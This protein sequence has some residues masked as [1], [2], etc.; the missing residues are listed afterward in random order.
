[1]LIT[2]FKKLDCFSSSKL[3][4]GL[5]YFIFLNQ[6]TAKQTKSKV[7][8]LTVRGTVNV[9]VTIFNVNVLNHAVLHLFESL[10][11]YL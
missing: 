9:E 7:R 2:L 3:K 4:V 10:H 1:M 8:V 5:F 11:Q 6:V